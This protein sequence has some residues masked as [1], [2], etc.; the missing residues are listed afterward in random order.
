MFHVKQNNYGRCRNYFM[1]D[2]R[3]VEPLTS[4]MRM[5]R[6]TNWAI[7][8]LERLFFLK[9]DIVSRET[10]KTNM[11][12]AFLAIANFLLFHVKQFQNG[13]NIVSRETIVDRSIKA[14]LIHLVSARG[15]EPRSRA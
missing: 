4:A 1:V 15:V 6:S 9:P 12:A 3:G 7:G 2:R 10:S 13:F 11:P 8:P 14:R 5:Q